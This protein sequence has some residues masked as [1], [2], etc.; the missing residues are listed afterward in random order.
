MKE[1]IRCGSCNKKFGTGTYIEITLK[2]PRCGCMN[3]FRAESPI[4][5]AESQRRSPVS[6]NPKRIAS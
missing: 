5:Q 4:N 6:D 1:D 3:N 2:C